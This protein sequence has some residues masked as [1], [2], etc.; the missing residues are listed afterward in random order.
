[1]ISKGKSMRDGM[2]RWC[3]VA[4]MALLCVSAGAGQ[5]S[6]RDAAAIDAVNEGLLKGLEARD[7][8][9]VMS[10]SPALERVTLHVRTAPTFS[11]CPG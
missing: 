9:K 6:S 11:Y 8:N 4:A 2:T 7:L 5:V 10:L 3:L 1:M